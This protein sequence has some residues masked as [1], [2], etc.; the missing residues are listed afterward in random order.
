MFRLSRQKLYPDE[1]LSK[2]LP[3]PIDGS[4]GLPG[5]LPALT[6]TA[7]AR[8]QLQTAN[9]VQQ[10]GYISEDLLDIAVYE[11]FLQRMK[12]GEFDDGA[13]YQDIKS[14]V[15]ESDEHV[16]KAEEAAEKS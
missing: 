1:A 9:A 15:I 5:G 13:T 4:K 6:V 14:S 10:E 2:I 16:A 7:A 11:L 8:A 12:T 3:A